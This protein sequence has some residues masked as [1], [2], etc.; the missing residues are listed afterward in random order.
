MLQTDY[1]KHG[2]ESLITQDNMDLAKP[3]YTRQYGFGKA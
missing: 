1:I 3:D 2:G